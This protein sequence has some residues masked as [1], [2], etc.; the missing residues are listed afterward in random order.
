MC[1]SCRAGVWHGMAGMAYVPWSTERAGRRLPWWWGARARLPAA[2][3]LLPASAWQ[4]AVER[5]V[6]DLECRPAC[7]PG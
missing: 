6:G 5:R 4:Q 1:L 7:L 2:C 3:G